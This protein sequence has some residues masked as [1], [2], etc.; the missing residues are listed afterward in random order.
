MGADVMQGMSLIDET[1]RLHGDRALRTLVAY[2]HGLAAQGNPPHWS[3]VDPAAIQDALEY[4]FLAD[5]LGHSHARLRVA[6]GSVVQLFGQEATGRPLSG[7]LS[8]EA[9][10]AFDAVMRRC[11]AVGR[12]LALRL[13]ASRRDVTGCMVLFPLRG[14]RGG[15][16]QLLGA[17]VMSGTPG[18]APVRFDFVEIEERGVSDRF[19]ACDARWIGALPQ[20]P[21][22][23]GKMKGRP[24]PSLRLVVN[25]G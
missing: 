14:D 7:L 5:R 21:E 18:P 12:P 2:W 1:L 17:L 15:V 3:E 6:G 20:T 8:P 19:G 23:T 22:F 4:A 9:R 10:P 24:E 16:T 25:N 11:F 13:G